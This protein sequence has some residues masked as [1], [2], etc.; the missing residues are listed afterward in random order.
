MPHRTPAYN[1]FGRIDLDRVWSTSSKNYRYLGNEYSQL[2]QMLSECMTNY[3]PF[4][5]SLPTRSWSDASR[6][7]R[8]GFNGKEKD[9]ETANDAYDF[10]ART[11]DGRLG[12]WLSVDPL[13]KLIPYHSSYVGFGNNPIQFIDFSGEIIVPANSFCFLYSKI[14]DLIFNNSYIVRYTKNID[15]SLTAENLTTALGETRVTDL[16]KMKQNVVMSSYFFKRNSDP[17]E[18]LKTFL[19]ECMHAYL[20]SEKQK[21]NG[22]KK[23]ELSQ[24]QKNIL[25]YIEKFGETKT[26]TTQDWT[27]NW[28]ADFGRQDIISA[29]KENDKKRKMITRA[30]SVTNEDGTFIS[31]TT[32]DYYEA[33]SWGGLIGTEAW[34]KLDSSK[35]VL[36]V[37]IQNQAVESNKPKSKKSKN[38]KS[39]D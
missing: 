11:Y 32:E 1:A 25:N 10:G 5:S 26:E 36:Y 30:G 4:G 34:N 37:K 28:I 12:R 13:M 20:N 31:Y 8:Y 18:F 19:H 35:K 39:N 22:K 29:M 15:I 6:A 27:H 17:T 21:I 38:K 14:Y 24:Y 7:Y 2:P 9:G 3:Y 16:S 23:N 33:L